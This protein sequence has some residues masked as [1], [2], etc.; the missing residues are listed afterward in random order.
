[1]QN[2]RPQELEKETSENFLLSS[3]KDGQ[4]M[5]DAGSCMDSPTETLKTEPFPDCSG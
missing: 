4:R 1:M 3:P 2:C 5:E